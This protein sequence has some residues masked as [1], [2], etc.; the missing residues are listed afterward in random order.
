MDDIRTS[1]L[2]AGAVYTYFPS[3]EALIEAAVTTSLSSLRSLSDV[4]SRDPPLAPAAFVGEATG[5][6]ARFAQREE[7]GLARIAI[8]GWSEAQRN[9]RLRA[10]VTGF[11]GA[12]REHLA[13]LAGRW[14]LAG[15]IDP[16]ADPESAAKMLLSL[17]LGFVVQSAILGDATAEDHASGLAAV[18]RVSP[19]R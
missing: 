4:C 3:K 8:H 12:F 10:T 9:E 19:L 14:R 16:D 11:Y 13:H 15:M 1:G 7:F 5:I 17:V 18:S 2:S 6:I